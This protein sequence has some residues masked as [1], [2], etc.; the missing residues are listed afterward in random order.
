VT[1]AD[2]GRPLRLVILGRQGSGKGTQ[3]ARLVEHYGTNHVSTG[4]MLRAAVSEGTELGRKAQA[5]MDAGNLV[6]D[7][8]MI[9]IVA[10]RLAKADVES[11]GVILDGFPRTPSQ[12]DALAKIVGPEGLDAA[13]NLD[14]PVEVV[15][16][17]MQQRGRIDD[18]PDAID[19][20]LELYERETAPLLDWFDG[21][22]LLVRV[23]G[24]GSEDEV[25]DRL[26]TAIEK[27]RR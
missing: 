3:C 10:E 16:A 24:L 11:G 20:R 23:D 18:T 1:D 8:I 13:I 7:D 22:G 2:R 14:V 6:S 27:A 17:R 26:V 21:R 5:V 12:A 19:R 25:F 9:G 4:D 15:R